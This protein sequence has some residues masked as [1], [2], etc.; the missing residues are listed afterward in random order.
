VSRRIVVGGAVVVVVLL[1][2]TAAAFSL[3]SEPSKAASASPAPVATATVERRDLLD[4]ESVEGTLGYGATRSVS[5]PRAGTITALPSLGDVVSRGES[6]FE[7]DGRPVPLFYG[8]RP[9]W[10]VLG[11]GADDGADVEELEENLVAAGYAP[12]G[13]DVDEH[14]SDATTAAV[15]R[16]QEALG[17]DETGIVAPGDVVFL[18]GPARVASVAAEV[19]AAAQPGGEPVITVTGTTRLVSVS[20]DA[21]KRALARAGEAVR[22]DLPDGGT[23]DGRILSVGTVAVTPESSSPD[24]NST[25]TIQVD[26]ALTHPETR[27]LAGLDATPVD[28][29]LT[30]SAARNV[31][32]VPVG[33]LT[34]LAEGG[35][36]VEVV[37]G[38]A[39]RLVGVTLG[40]F[41]DGWVQ[42]K[43]DVRP[44][45][46]VVVPS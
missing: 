20:L 39:T 34:A 25:P 38:A 45:A 14:W 28:V 8:A 23:F 9:M 5:S 41:A 46:K 24:D 21:S 6:L 16:W 32:A 26:I 44:G 3:R 4:R 10:R 17:Q 36:A 12:D 35:Y 15:K 18:R 2:A 13:L 40:P 31:L 29:E 11:P 7:I 43:G 33:A 42:V 27:A 37:S 30:R 19:G 1:G 22:V